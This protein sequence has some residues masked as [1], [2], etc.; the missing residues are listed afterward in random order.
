MYIFIIT[1]INRVIRKVEMFFFFQTSLN[2]FTCDMRK[3]KKNKNIRRRVLFLSNLKSISQF[4]KIIVHRNGTIFNIG[5]VTRVS[6][7]LLTFPGIVIKYQKNRK[8]I[9]SIKCKNGFPSS[10]IDSQRRRR[11]N[12]ILETNQ[13]IASYLQTIKQTVFKN[14]IFKLTLFTI[15]HLLTSF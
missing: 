1:I 15:F 11:R 6:T 2:L 13:V 14:Q 4:E 9:F 10:E 3:W 12:K 5:I 8:K 7:V